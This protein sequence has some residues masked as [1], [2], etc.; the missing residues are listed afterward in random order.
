MAQP[1]AMQTNN[2]QNQNRG[3]VEEQKV[4][5]WQKVMKVLCCG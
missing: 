4:S 2:Q 5:G 3:G 1:G